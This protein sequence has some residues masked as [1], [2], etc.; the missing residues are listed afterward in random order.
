MTY[1][2]FKFLGVSQDSSSPLGT[3]ILKAHGHSGHAPEGAY[4]VKKGLQA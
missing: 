3:F 1:I 4:S 2:G